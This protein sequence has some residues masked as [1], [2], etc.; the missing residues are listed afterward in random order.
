MKQITA[1]LLSQCF[2]PLSCLISETVSTQDLG[3]G[4]KLVSQSEFRALSHPIVTPPLPLLVSSNH[5]TIT[6]KICLNIDLK[7]AL[8]K[9]P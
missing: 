1:A 4:W 2:S 8:F 7:K 5:S 9:S 3:F 6:V